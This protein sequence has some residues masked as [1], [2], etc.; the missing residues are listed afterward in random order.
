MVQTRSMKLRDAKRGVLTDADANVNDKKTEVLVL[1][2]TAAKASLPPEA[3]RNAASPRSFTGKCGLWKVD[4]FEI[5]ETLK[6]EPGD[7]AKVYKARDKKSGYVVA[8]KVQPH[9]VMREFYLNDRLDHPRVVKCFDR[10]VDG[11]G[12][13]LTRYMTLEHCENGSLYDAVC[14]SPA[15]ICEKDAAS[16]MRDILDG[17]A[18]LHRR[19][20]IHGNIKPRNI[21]IDGEGRAK[22][23]DT[24]APCS[25]T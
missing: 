4:D 6:I 12:T 22:I 24:V 19:Q 15:G 1:E 23:L 8:L 20:S 5:L 16:Y 14:N 13:A 21:L 2:K 17:L 10:F 3:S 7:V 25:A 11:D 18:Y 9:S